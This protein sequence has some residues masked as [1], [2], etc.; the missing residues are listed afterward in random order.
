MNHGN[1]YE[2]KINDRAFKA[3]KDGR[4]KV[5]I[6]VTKVGTG[7]DYSILKVGDFINF[8]SY[9][10]EKMICEIV[11]IN[12]YETIEELL[13]KE[14]TKYTLSSTD[15]FDEGVKSIKS[16]DGY[17]EGMKQNGVYALHI[18]PIL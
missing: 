5:E 9:D 7:F 1:F 16:F 8:T 18:K 10:K 2:L 15:D 4:K 14:G 3:I 17:D 6:R 12:W 11:K 13:T